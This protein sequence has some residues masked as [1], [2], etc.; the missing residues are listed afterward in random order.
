MNTNTQR[1][2]ILTEAQRAVVRASKLIVNDT[3]KTDPN[4]VISELNAAF[5][6]I[7]TVKGM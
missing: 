3:V 5:G 7:Q 1:N 4:A 6:L 2:K